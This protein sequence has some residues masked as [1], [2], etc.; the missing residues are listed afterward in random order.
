MSQEDTGFLFDVCYSSSSFEVST[1]DMGLSKN[2]SKQ[3]SL[4][5]ADSVSA[6]VSFPSSRKR[7]ISNLQ[8]DLMTWLALTQDSSVRLLRHQWVM[9]L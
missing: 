5:A 1:E 7:L 3:G 9:P 2:R 4:P 6:T 8:F